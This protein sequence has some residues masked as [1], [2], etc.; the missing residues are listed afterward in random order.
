MAGTKLQDRLCCRP[1]PHRTGVAS[2]FNYSGVWSVGQPSSSRLKLPMGAYFPFLSPLL[3]GRW[4]EVYG[5]QPIA[6]GPL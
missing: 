6:P 2:L 5:P 4:L 1:R 3:K